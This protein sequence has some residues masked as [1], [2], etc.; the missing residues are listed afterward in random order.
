VFRAE[1]IL[2]ER[3]FANEK[4]EVLR[5][6]FIDEISGEDRFESVSVKNVKDNKITKLKFDGLFVSI[7]TDPN[8]GF[9]R[10]IVEFDERGKIKVD[11]SMAT[12][13]TGIFA[14]GDVTSNCPEQMAAAVGSGVIAALSVNE[15]LEKL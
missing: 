4:I 1:K 2:Q 3:I 14:A 10:E 12:S 15:Y 6:S 11:S 13:Q 5:D 7:G 9:L 8:T